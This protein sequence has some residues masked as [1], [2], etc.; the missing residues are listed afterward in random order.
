MFKALSVV[1]TVAVGA[2]ISF[3]SSISGTLYWTSGTLVNQATPSASPQTVVVKLGGT[4]RTIA[5][6]LIPGSTSV[7]IEAGSPVEIL[8]DSSTPFAATYTATTALVLANDGSGA[9]GNRSIK[10][11]SSGVMQSGIMFPISPFGSAGLSFAMP[12]CTIG[13]VYIFKNGP[14]ISIDTNITSYNLAIPTSPTGT[15]FG[16]IAIPAG[17]SPVEEFAFEASGNGILSFTGIST[18]N[19]LWVAGNIQGTATTFTSTN[20]SITP[21][22]SF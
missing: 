20:M 13:G 11:S 15:T 9:E 10:I 12:P 17:D 21:T 8:E 3:A 18:N 6:I 4:N 7:P 16:S 1:A 19:T 2:A 22:S 14:L 5:N